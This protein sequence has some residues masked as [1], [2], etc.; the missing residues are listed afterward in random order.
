MSMTWRGGVGL[1]QEEPIV[2]GERPQYQTVYLEPPTGA[3]RMLGVFS[4]DT[5]NQTPRN[6]EEA[7][8]QE[9][10]TLR[11]VGYVMH[12][13][14]LDLDL[15]GTFGADQSF[16]SADGTSGETSGT[17]G[18]WDMR[19]TLL[20]D[21]NLPL[22]LFSQRE[23]QWINREFGPTL[24][25][26]STNTG[27][28]LEIR[29]GPIP[30]RIDVGHSTQQQTAP[31]GAEDLELTRDYF[32]WFASARIDDVQNLNWS[33]VYNAIDQNSS[34]LG[35]YE[36]HT[37]TV[38]Y[39]RRFGDR[40]QHQWTSSLYYF[41]QS[42]DFELQ[43]L[44]LNQLVRMRHSED[45]DTRYQYI[46]DHNTFADSERSRHR[47]T[48]GFTHRLY[49][50][51]V[52]NGLAG[53]Q[54][55]SST[56]GDNSLELNG[57]LGFDY[58]KRV[59]LGQLS[60]GLNVGYSVQQNEARSGIVQIV[61]DVESFPPE[62]RIIIIG[63]SIV[64]GSVFITDPS[65]IVLTPDV[66]Y[67]LTTTDNFIQI[68]R[69]VGGLIPA[70]GTILVDYRLA[71]EAAS[72]ITTGRIGTRL[73]YDIHEG[74][75]KGLGFFGGIRLQEQDIDMDAP[76]GLT[77][78]SFTDLHYGVDYRWQGLTLS[79]EQQHHDS[80]ILPFD[81]TRAA[82]R[83]QYRLG[84]DTTFGANAAWTSIHYPDDRNR[85]DLMTFS[86]NVRHNF[87]PQLS[88]SAAVLWRD[89]TDNLHGD[90]HG[91]EQQAELRWRHRQVDVF[92]RLRNSMFDTSEEERTFQ[93]LEIGIQREF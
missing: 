55:V 39:D 10:L 3:L 19:A 86:A 56:D 9:T 65:G 11:T 63:H 69:V 85:V 84:G 60:A 50:S 90:T 52:T 7:Y 14:F 35:S 20:R 29:T 40:R 54:Y 4:R 45:F 62:D 15:S 48:A 64:P 21:G 43:T 5:S 72:T 12:P 74:P 31:D 44:R 70:G 46:F 76:D 2:I 66:D 75:L 1:A 92:A 25:N 80:T 34:F 16:F 82:A 59:P 38:G 57:D 89:Q 33:Y 23:Q 6:F 32:S 41:T 36:T 78:N 79:I 42:G 22:T 83:Y 37:A 73:R 67:T 18:A 58:T 87:T 68:D 77:P 27:A 51:L 53:M 91:F 17:V 28:S 88:G 49:E 81:A 30:G 8:F 93:R 61:D 47:A 24:R 13:N 71:P 26:T